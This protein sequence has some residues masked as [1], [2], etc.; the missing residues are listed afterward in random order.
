MRVSVLEQPVVKTSGRDEIALIGEQRRT[1]A[2][3]LC[4]LVG[5]NQRFGSVEV[6]TRSDQPPEFVLN[7]ATGDEYFSEHVAQLVTARDPG[8]F[9]E[10]LERLSVLQGVA[11]RPP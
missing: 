2:D 11:L 8:G 7:R 10:Q 3:Q 1:L 4:D 6:A 9:I 5:W